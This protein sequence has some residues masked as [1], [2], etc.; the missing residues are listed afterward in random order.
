LGCQLEVAVSAGSQRGDPPL[1][2]S[3]DFE[4]LGFAQP[5]TDPAAIELDQP[6]VVGA[7]L[8]QVTIELGEVVLKPPKVH[9]Q[10]I[11]GRHPQRV[12]V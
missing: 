6:P 1:L 7:R 3:Q 5:V 2:P 12:T 8:P 4:W 11:E 9:F 10:G